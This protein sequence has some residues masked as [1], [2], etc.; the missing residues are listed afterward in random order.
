MFSHVPTGGGEM[1]F[2]LNYH[3]GRVFLAQMDAPLFG[4]RGLGAVL[5]N[6]LG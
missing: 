6:L 4:G 1:N 2:S 5:Y 3:L